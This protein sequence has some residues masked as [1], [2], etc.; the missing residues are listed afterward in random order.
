MA[1][2]H[3]VFSNS[4]DIRHVVCLASTGAVLDIRGTTDNPPEKDVACGMTADAPDYYNSKYTVDSD[5]LI[6][7]GGKNGPLPRNV[8]EAEMAKKNLSP[9][10]IQNVWDARMKKYPN[11]IQPTLRQ[12]K[13]KKPRGLN[14]NPS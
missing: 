8:I 9:N 5:K 11:G 7:I 3:L 13:T 12:K 2:V 10:E 4:G 6:Y 1:Q 14:P